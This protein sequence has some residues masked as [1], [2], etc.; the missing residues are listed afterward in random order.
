MK[1]FRISSSYS[2]SVSS[3]ANYNVTSTP[4]LFVCTIG[5]TDI[6][7]CFQPDSVDCQLQAGETYLTVNEF[8]IDIGEQ[9]FLRKSGSINLSYQKRR[10]KASINASFGTNEYLESDRETESKRLGIQTSYELGKRTNIGINF[11]VSKRGN[12]DAEE[13]DTIASYGFLFRRTISK[14]LELNVNARIVNR[15]S[16]IAD[17]NINDKR[18]T[19]GITYQF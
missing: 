15:Q 7:E 8:D 18:L 9:V 11:N 10:L 17:R 16:D 13:L 3:F 19:T 5:A 1:Y 6:S 12:G 2:E 14:N 4:Q